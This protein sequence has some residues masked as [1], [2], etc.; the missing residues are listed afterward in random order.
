MCANNNF[1]FKEET[2]M[3]ILYVILD[4]FFRIAIFLSRII[5]FF[6]I[7]GLSYVVEYYNIT[8][9]GMA[10]L[11]IVLLFYATNVAVVGIREKTLQFE[12]FN[13]ALGA[14]FFICVCEILISG[15][16]SKLLD[17][18]FLKTFQVVH[19]TEAV[20]DTLRGNDIEED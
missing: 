20:W 17:V 8:N 7:L 9:Q 18:D 6:I 13:E 16:S 2:L 4:M 11:V 15:I 19:F 10:F 5:L 12:N 3:S 14:V 1:K